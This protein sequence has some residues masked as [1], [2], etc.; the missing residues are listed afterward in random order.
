MARVPVRIEVDPA[1]LRAAD[2]PYLVGDPS[3]ADR[4]CGWRATRPFAD[5]LGDVLEDWRRSGAGGTG[6]S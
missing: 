2:L 6:R 5:T 1:R 3:R 4:E